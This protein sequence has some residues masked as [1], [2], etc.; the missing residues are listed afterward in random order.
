M[1]HAEVQTL[2]VGFLNTPT[3]VHVLELD[4]VLLGGHVADLRVVDL[5]SQ[6]ILAD[7]R[8]A[9]V[10][11]DHAGDDLWQHDQRK[12]DDVEQRQAQERF[13][14]HHALEL[15]SDDTNGLK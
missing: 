5:V 13:G 12:P 7:S 15:C 6:Q 4:R 3:E 9:H 1:L 8:H 10:G 14:V 11:L 2:Q